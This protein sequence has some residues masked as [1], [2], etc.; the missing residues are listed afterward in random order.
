[1]ETLHLYNDSDVGY[2][3]PEFMDFEEASEKEEYDKQT[4]IIAI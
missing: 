2:I 1:M 3:D 4:P